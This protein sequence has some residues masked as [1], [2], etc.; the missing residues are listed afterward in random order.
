MSVST[1]ANSVF[2]TSPSM[3]AKN[4]APE[5]GNVPTILKN[6]FVIGDALDNGSSIYE[7]FDIN[8]KFQKCMIKISDNIE[9]LNNEIDMLKEIKMKEASD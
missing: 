5:K 3:K 2:I 1:N 4:S 6:R 7:C 8:N 9:N